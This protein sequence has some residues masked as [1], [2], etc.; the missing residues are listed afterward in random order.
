MGMMICMMNDGSYMTNGTRMC[1][2]SQQFGGKVNFMAAAKA[3]VAPVAAMILGE[4]KIRYVDSQGV[5]PQVLYDHSFDMYV[6]MPV[7]WPD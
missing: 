2:P 6:I 1:E 5:I 3:Y 7:T 4:P